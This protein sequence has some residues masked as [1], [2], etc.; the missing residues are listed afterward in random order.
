MAGTVGR[1]QVAPM[2]R[3]IRILICLTEGD[4]WGVPISRLLRMA[5]LVE[6]TDASRAQL[7]RDLAILRRGGWQIENIAPKGSDARYVL[8]VRDNRLA[9]LLTPGERAA[10]RQVLAYAA[11]DRSEPPPFLGELQH[12]VTDGCLTSFTYRGTRRSVHPDALFATPSGWVLDAREQA[13]GQTKEFVTAWMGDLEVGDPGTASRLPEPAGRL[14]PLQWPSD[15]PVVVTLGVVPAF[16][17]DVLYQLPGAEVVEHG[18]EEMVVAVRV[19]NRAV[20]RARLY[21]LG[22]RARVLGPPGAVADIVGNLRAVAGGAGTGG[23]SAGGA[24][25]GGD[26]GRLR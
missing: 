12:A 22:L 3:L 9:V 11:G 18:P 23:G 25:A 20:C 1:D 8:R 4:R 21:A 10:L 13:D 6:D 7:R 16:L 19:T 14:D 26:H 5:D 24:S 15:E 2:E 17:D